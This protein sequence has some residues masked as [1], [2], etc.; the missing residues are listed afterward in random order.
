MEVFFVRNGIGDLSSN[1][2]RVSVSL[3]FN[4]FGGGTNPSVLPPTM[5]KKKNKRFLWP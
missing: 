5:N 3:C 4:V 1:P 2:G